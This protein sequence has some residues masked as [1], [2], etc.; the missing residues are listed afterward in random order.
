MP[1]GGYGI[2]SL[3]F[4]MPLKNYYTVL[5][6]PF[7]QIYCKGIIQG[8]VLTRHFGLK[9]DLRD[10]DDLPLIMESSINGDHAV[11]AEYLAQQGV[12]K[13][14]RRGNYD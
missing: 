9:P 5:M 13:H 3:V 8:R 1:R 10:T 11:R 14:E 7:H 12:S 4:E 6:K 2:Q